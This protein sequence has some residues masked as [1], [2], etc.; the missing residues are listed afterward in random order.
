MMKIMANKQ[1]GF[2]FSGFLMIAFILVFAAI[3]GMK[4][5]PAYI[6]DHEINS[7]FNTIARD[8]EM[9]GA[10]KKDVLESFYKRA[11]MNN[12]KVVST[13]DIEINQEGGRLSLSASYI[14][15]IPLAGNASLLL[16]F[17]PSS[18]R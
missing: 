3:G 13:D 12:I 18:S 15:K 7:I 4:V 10:K 11:M 8:P 16:E 9:Q 1:R 14:V 17:N 5:L 6:Q 2:S